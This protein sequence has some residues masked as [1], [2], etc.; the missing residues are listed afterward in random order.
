MEIECSR[1]AENEFVVVSMQDSA[2]VVHRRPIDVVTPES[3]L[4]RLRSEFSFPERPLGFSISVPGSTHIF[5]TL[6]RL[7]IIRHI[8]PDGREHP[9]LD[10]GHR[11]EDDDGLRRRPDLAGQPSFADFAGRCDAGLAHDSLREGTR[12]GMTSEEE[13]NLQLREGD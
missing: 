12:E 4:K 8:S 3:G 13:Y 11:R 2:H 9:L 7:A 10:V 5:F 6:I 1:P